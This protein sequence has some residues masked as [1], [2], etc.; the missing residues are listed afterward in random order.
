MLVSVESTDKF[1]NSALAEDCSVE[2]FR[3]SEASLDQ[4]LRRTTANEALRTAQRTRGQKGLEAWRATARRYDQC[5]GI[6]PCTSYSRTNDYVKLR[7]NGY[8]IAY[9]FTHNNIMLEHNA[10]NNMNT[11][12]HM[13]VHNTQY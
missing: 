3:T 4:V 9:N 10:M 11:V 7:I 12:A 5:R 13:D 8:D 1:D 2:E 6:K